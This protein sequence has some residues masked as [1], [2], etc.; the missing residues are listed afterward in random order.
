MW[1]LTVHMVSESVHVRKWDKDFWILLTYIYICTYGC[2]HV[3]IYIDRVFTF[4]TV[5]V[6]ERPNFKGFLKNEYRFR[7]CFMTHAEL[8]FIWGVLH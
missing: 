2:M 8:S 3:C 7:D 5:E 6:A 4:S 1:I